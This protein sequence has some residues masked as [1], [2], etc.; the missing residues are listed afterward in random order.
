MQVLKA[1]PSALHAPVLHE[2]H[3]AKV[4]DPDKGGRRWGIVRYSNDRRLAPSAA[5]CKRYSA[6]VKLCPPTMGLTSPL[7]V[8]CRLMVRREN[9]YS[10]SRVISTLSP[11]RIK[12][13]P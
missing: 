2:F 12:T 6:P 8:E 1:S 9:A 7:T 5:V 10:V 4:A 13:Q 11:K 3:V